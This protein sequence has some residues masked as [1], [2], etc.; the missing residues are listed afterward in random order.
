M[1]SGDW[2]FPYFIVSSQR[3]NL[4]DSIMTADSPSLETQDSLTPRAGRVAVV[5]SGP[6]GFYAAEAVLKQLPGVEVDIIERLPSPYGLV[7]SGVAPD[8][9]KIKSVIA[10]FEQIA[11]KPQVRFIGN[12]TVGKDIQVDELFDYY[13]AV[14]FCHGAETDRRLNI[15]GEDLL[16][17]HT[18]TEFVGWYNGHPEYSHLTFDLS[19][20][21]AVI[22]GQGNVAIDVARILSKTVEE[23][24]QTDIADHALEA[25]RHK[26]IK[27]V[28]LVGRRG[29]VQAKFTEKELREL[30]EL[31]EFDPAVNSDDLDL[32]PEDEQE[33]AQSQANKAGK[34]VAIFRDFANRLPEKS[35]RLH[36]AFL[37][38]PVSISGTDKVASI[39]LERNNLTGEA[40]S[41]VAVAT[42]EIKDLP[43]QLVFRSV[44]YKGV[45]LQGLPFDEKRSVVPS[46]QG[47]VVDSEGRPM[48]GYYVAGW[49]KRGPSGVI[50]TNKACSVETVKSLAIDWE[51]LCVR[52]VAEAG[53]FEK[54]LT[55]SKCQV[56]NFEAWKRIDAEEVKRGSEKNKPRAKI[57]SSEE[58]IRL[59]SIPEIVL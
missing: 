7:R 12:V 22:I 18:A 37:Q 11:Q 24:E 36:I 45:P 30:G 39:C 19:G 56:V 15:P 47:R 34:N 54:Y 42:G 4:L 48:T 57:V 20:D 16:G 6:S 41:R 44:G 17:S 25:L 31:A 51:Q 35:G 32:A 2:K 26:Q 43:C 58:M 49:I 1:L 9:P 55:N 29:P 33:M 13:H 28:Y 5:G 10:V 14:I 21:T 27:N 46:S 23:L 38:S 50:G 3:F 52:S 53:S 8:H 59:A 40:N